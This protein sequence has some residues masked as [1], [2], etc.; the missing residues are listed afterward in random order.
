LYLIIRFK[1]AATLINHLALLPLMPQKDKGMFWPN[2]IR[3]EDLLTETSMLPTSVDLEQTRWRWIGHVLRMP[4]HFLPGTVLRCT[5]HGK[6]N[7]GRPKVTRR[8]TTE[9]MLTNRNL[10]WEKE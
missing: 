6:R 8:R 4:E 2:T 9:R 7:T 3:N 5:S 1:S 10:K